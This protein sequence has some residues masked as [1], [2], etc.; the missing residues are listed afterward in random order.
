MRTGQELTLATKRYAKDSTSKSWWHLLS[1][2]VLYIAAFAGTLWNFHPVAQLV[3]SLL[4]ALML[5]R[6]FVIY[7]DQ[8]HHAILPKSRLADRLMKFFG[9][10]SLNASS[11]WRSSHNHHHSHNSKLRGS[12]IGSFPI[13]TR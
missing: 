1:T 11:V 7:H 13:M 6:L 12:H 9:M 2:G 5:L 3:F 8:Q 10:L 4:S